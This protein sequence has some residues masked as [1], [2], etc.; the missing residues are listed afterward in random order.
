MIIH[1]NRS[2][3]EPGNTAWSRNL[4]KTI[5]FHTSSG[6]VVWRTLTRF[7]SLRIDLL[8]SAQIATTVLQFRGFI[9]LVLGTDSMRREMLR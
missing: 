6:I 2:C 8:Q 5:P 7:N 9:M 4:T 1:A 3:K